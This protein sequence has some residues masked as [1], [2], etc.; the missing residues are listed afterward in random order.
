M[1]F[2]SMVTQ[3]ATQLYESAIQT[4]EIVSNSSYVFSGDIS[5]LL[6]LLSALAILLLFMSLA[7]IHIKRVL[8]RPILSLLNDRTF[9]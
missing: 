9:K 1:L 8:K 2:R 7:M 6:I 4:S 5:L 3:T